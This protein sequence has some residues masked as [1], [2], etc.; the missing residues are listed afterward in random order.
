MYRYYINITLLYILNLLIKRRKSFNKEKDCFN[1]FKDV[2]ITNTPINSAFLWKLN[3]IWWEREQSTSLPYFFYL[4]FT[5]GFMNVQSHS[6]MFIASK[7]SSWS[8]FVVGMY[9]FIY[10]FDEKR[11]TIHYISFHYLL[12]FYFTLI[13]FAC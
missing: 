8:I 7:A 9:I 2:N 3:G 6:G 5:R 10:I 12:E 11:C 13:M 1:F 4:S